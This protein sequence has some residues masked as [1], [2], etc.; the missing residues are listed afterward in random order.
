MEGHWRRVNTPLRK[1]TGRE[2]NV[3]IAGLTATAVA[4]MA[5][6]LLTAGDSRPG[7]K[8][9]CISVVVAGRVGG[10]PVSACGAEAR[11]ICAR[12][13]QFDVPRSRTILAACRE[14]GIETRTAPGAPSR[15][16]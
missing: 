16:G 11:A 5:I 6:L 3:L 15:G 13:A 12:S 9:G 4:I 10:E 8:P 7:P 2:R 14:Q 1:V